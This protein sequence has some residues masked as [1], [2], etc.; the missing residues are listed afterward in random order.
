MSKGAIYMLGYV[1]VSATGHVFINH[2][3]R[4][5][6]PFVS[7]LYTSL[8]TI[9]F[10]SVLHLGELRKHRAL[11]KQHK[12]AIVWLNVLNAIIWFVAFFCL[13]A[14][15]PAVFACL[16]LGAIPIQ[17]FLIEIRKSSHSVKTKW[18]TATLLF[19]L[20]IL[21][22]ALVVQET[23]GMGMATMLQYG[24]I[25]VGIGGVAAASILKISKRLA[26]EKLSASLVVSL[27]FYGVLM[28]SLA[29][30]IIYQVPLVISPS[31]GIELVVLALV[32]MALP[33][34]LLQKGLQTFSPMSASIVITII[35]VLTYC[36][37][38]CTG[39][40][41]FSFP[42]LGIILLCSLVLVAL[43][44]QKHNTKAA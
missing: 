40:Y 3:V 22:L 14:L 41:S 36:L 8:I 27:R 26:S 28:I 21:M 20:F 29:L 2:T 13:K 32:S 4:S 9:L 44:F 43:A 25:V 33:L 1:V 38:L 6:D 15:S 35:P 34:F 12:G 5:V 18:I 19:T 39:Y 31:L 37:Q 11:V 42:K 7:L 17:L 23:E 30:C 24:L 10:F 16:F